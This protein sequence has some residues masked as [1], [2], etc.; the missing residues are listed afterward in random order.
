IVAAAASSDARVRPAMST[1]QPSAASTCA[2][3][4]PMPL[5]APVT[6]AR[7]PVRPRSIA[8]LEL[9]RVELGRQDDLEQLAVV[10]IVEHGMLDLGRLQPARALAH[11]LDLAVVLALHPALEHIDHLEVD[12]VVVTLGDHLGNA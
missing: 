12:G 3:A 1:A 10:G 2:I 6:S 7:L 4:S 11:G 9:D 5:L 8:R